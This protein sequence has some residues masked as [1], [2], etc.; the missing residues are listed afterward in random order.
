[1]VGDWKDFAITILL[2]LVMLSFGIGY[3]IGRD[4]GME[5]GFALRGLIEE[6]KRSEQ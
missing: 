5:D 6:R 3:K 2:F 4:E 1:M